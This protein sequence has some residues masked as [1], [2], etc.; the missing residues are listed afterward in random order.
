MIVVDT[1]VLAYLFL[2][3]TNTM[4]A[5]GVLKQDSEWA[6]P[7]LWRSE[8]RNILSTYLRNGHLALGDAKSIISDAEK[9]MARREFEVE[10]VKVLDL[11]YRSGCRAYDCEFIVLAEDLGV[12]FVTSDRKLVRSFPGT[13][14]SM[15]DFIV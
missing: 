9:L 5:E 2:Q 8:F 3:G 15:A 7:Y 10:S 1:N 13:A 12:P 14:I 11:A 4:E 6:A